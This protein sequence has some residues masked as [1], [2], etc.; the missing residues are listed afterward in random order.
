MATSAANVTAGD[1]C[2]VSGGGPL[3]GRIKPPGD[4]SISH[5]ALILAALAEGE[6]VLAG[7]SGGQ[8]VVHTAQ[9]LR[10]LGA[11]ID[12]PAADDFAGGAGSVSSAGSAAADDPAE[13]GK[14]AAPDE[15]TV[16]GGQL[17]QPEEVLYV[18]NSG[19]SLRLLSGMCAG[20]GFAVTLDGDE[21]LR[22]RPMDR[23]AEPLSQMGA[24]VKAADSADPGDPAGQLHAPL[25]ISAD[26]QLTGIDYSLPIPSAQVKGAVLLAGLNAS[27]ETTVTET[28]ITRAHT[29]EMLSQWQADIST[30]ST[31]DGQRFVRLNPSQLSGRKFRIWGDPSQSAFWAVVAVC[32]PDSEVAVDDM[33]VGPGRDGYIKVLEQMGASIMARPSTRRLHIKFKPSELVGVDIPAEQ[34][35]GLIDEIPALAVAAAHAQG[36]TRFA[37]VGELRAKESDRIAATTALI[38]ALGGRA[39]AEGDTLVV[40]GT[41]GLK[42]GAVDSCGDHRIAMAA[43]VA[44]LC[45]A[46]ETVIE[47]WSCVDT[48]YPGFLDDLARL[49]QTGE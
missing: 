36:E 42:A 13:T 12:W 9:A 29:E 6:S 8:D 2:V 19:T 28:H 23:I 41:G 32:V 33:Y 22:R 31:D 27:S 43:A 16:R 44:G 25:T 3:N 46:G 20:L 21:S 15:A 34:V 49:A 1:T 14:L 24:E 37:G 5:R 17:R 47:G 35:P 45:V 4:K 11:E 48:S 30:G 10:Q 26:R 18:G 40:H 7:L 38:N 39:E